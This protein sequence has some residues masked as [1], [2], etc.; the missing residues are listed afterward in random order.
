MDEVFGETVKVLDVILTTPS[1][2]AEAERS[3]STLK[4]VK[5]SSRNRMGQDRLNSLVCMSIHKDLEICNQRII[6]EFASRKER[7][8]ELLFK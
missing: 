2:T 3:F 7:R 6:D 1:T 5:S 8:A 4:R